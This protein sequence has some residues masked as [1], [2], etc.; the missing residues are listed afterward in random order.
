MSKRNEKTDQR[1]VSIVEAMLAVAVLMI[2]VLAAI[3]IFP[4]VLK[5]SKNAEQKTIA[6][7][8]AQAAI[9]QAFQ[10]D[11][12]NLAIGDIEPKHRLAADSANPFYDYQRETVAVYV[13]GNLNVSA[14]AT[15][16]K[17]ITATVFWGSSYLG[18]EKSLPVSIL[19]S[20]K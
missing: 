7:N 19:I 16:L 17:K 13:D 12:D 10:T 20:Q 5:I 4:A 18:L 8:L 1:G 6:A 14:A 15:G 3:N 11:F 2:G 9:E